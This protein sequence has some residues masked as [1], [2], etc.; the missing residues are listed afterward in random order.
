MGKSCSLWQNHKF[1]LTAELFLLCNDIS[2]QNLHLLSLLFSAQDLSL[3][4]CFCKAWHRNPKAGSPPWKEIVSASILGDGRRSPVACRSS[5]QGGRGGT[6]KA[7]GDC[8]DSPVELLPVQVEGDLKIWSSLEVHKHPS[9]V[10]SCQQEVHFRVPGFLVLLHSWAQENPTLNSS[11]MAVFAS[12]YL[13]EVEMAVI[14]QSGDSSVNVLVPNLVFCTPALT[15]S[16]I[17][18]SAVPTPQGQAAQGQNAELKRSDSRQPPQGSAW[19]Y[20]LEGW[21]DMEHV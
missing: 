21:N 5:C 2:E 13:T 3:G 8:I 7:A 20:L 4:L 19:C 6:A 11:E 1:L 12:P 14:R 9:E 18:S 15:A 16:L 10:Q 17:T